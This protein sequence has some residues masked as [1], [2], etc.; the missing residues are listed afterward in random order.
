MHVVVGLVVELDHH[1][2][3]T[4]LRCHKSSQLMMV[5]LAFPHSHREPRCESKR[6]GCSRRRRR[7]VDCRSS[8]VDVSV[9]FG[10][11]EFDIQYRS[12]IREDF[13]SQKRQLSLL[14]YLYCI[15]SENQNR[16]TPT[17]KVLKNY[18]VNHEPPAAP[19][20]PTIRVNVFFLISSIFFSLFISVINRGEKILKSL[21]TP[22]V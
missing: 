2:F 6:L 18:L 9:F 17:E 14:Y 11:S 15:S 5:S 12:V 13:A 8:S 22:L 19:K 20:K 10:G 16:D 3:P 4:Q 7:D 1:R 21:C